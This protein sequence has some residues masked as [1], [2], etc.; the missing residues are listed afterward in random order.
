LPAGVPA[1]QRDGLGACR[2]AGGY[3]GRGMS[4]DAL[5]VFELFKIAAAVVLAVVL[6]GALFALA[7]VL[8]AGLLVNLW[9]RWGK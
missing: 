9:K 5:F 8:V 7:L 6:A 2:A 1:V 3:G 4:V